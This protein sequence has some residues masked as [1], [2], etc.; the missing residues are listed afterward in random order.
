MVVGGGAQGGLRGA[1]G[2]VLA[3]FAQ[4][5]DAGAR[6]AGFVDPLRQWSTDEASPSGIA[7]TADGTVWM[8]ALRGE[9]LWRIP[10]RD[11]V[12]GQPQRLLHGEYGRLRDVVVGPDGRLWVLTNNTARG[13]PARDDDKLIV[14]PVS[15][16]H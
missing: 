4:Q 8:A 10:T 6:R 12:A 16:L 11:G 5:D 13:N 7:N 15:T 9:S 3:G 1:V 14:I 2:R